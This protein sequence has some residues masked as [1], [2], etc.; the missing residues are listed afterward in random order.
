MCS[1]PGNSS[2]DTFI[3]SKVDEFVA[4]A[5]AEPRIS[6]MNPWHYNNRCV[7]GGTDFQCGCETPQS[8]CIPCNASSAGTPAYWASGAMSM[9]RTLAKLQAV[10][11]GIKAG[12]HQPLQPPPLEAN[13]GPAPR[14]APPASAASLVQITSNVSGACLDRHHHAWTSPALLRLADCSAG[15]PALRDIAWEF[16]DG[17]L[18]S[19]CTDAACAGMQCV[20]H[21]ANGTVGLVGCA[22]RSGI[23]RLS[24]DG[25]RI[26]GGG[27]LCLGIRGCDYTARDSAFELEACGAGGGCGGKNQLW[28]VAQ[29]RGP[30][31]PPPPPPPAPPAPPVGPCSLNGVLKG[32]CART[33]CSEF[34][35]AFSRKSLAFSNQGS[36]ECYSYLQ[37]HTHV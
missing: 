27:G 26:R 32:A 29:Y 14:P 4:W 31:V 23:L 7:R 1:A 11:A 36:Q 22:N 17:G 3:S 21:L 15:N 9:P 37:T 33:M 25:Q 19:A 2:Y 20:G 24:L 13:D 16:A 34:S 30:P 6:G 12:A 8:C 10:G 35:P 18:R 5:K 28:T